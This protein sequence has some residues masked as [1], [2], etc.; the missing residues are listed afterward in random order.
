MCRAVTLVAQTNWKLDV[1][2]E[3]F[4]L[5]NHALLIGGSNCDKDLDYVGS[6]IVLIQGKH[7]AS[8]FNSS[9]P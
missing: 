8:P 2:R 6:E 9:I 4:D 5:K 1:K 7:L 3:K